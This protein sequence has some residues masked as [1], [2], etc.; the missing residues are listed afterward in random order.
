MLMGSSKKTVI[1]VT[2]NERPDE[3]QWDATG[4]RERENTRRFEK[5][6]QR[7]PCSPL[8]SRA[9]HPPLTGRTTGQH[10]QL[11][12]VQIDAAGG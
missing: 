3:K 5:I 11:T 12:C 8:K 2:S 10:D 9:S 6:K 4:G 1:L 7:R